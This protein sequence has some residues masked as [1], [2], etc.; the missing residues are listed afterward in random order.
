MLVG[1]SFAARNQPKT[2]C[3][4]RLVALKQ[5]SAFSQGPCEN[6]MC[7]PERKINGIQAFFLILPPLHMVREP[8]TSVLCGWPNTGRSSAFA[9]WPGFRTQYSAPT[10]I[11]C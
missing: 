11:E 2:R 8:G 7:S 6:G 9:R 3:C 10:Y 4:T 5:W 1:R